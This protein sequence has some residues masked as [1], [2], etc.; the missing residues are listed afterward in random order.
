LGKGAANAAPPPEEPQETKAEATPVA[1]FAAPAFSQSGADVAALA[2]TQASR[3]AKDAE[4]N[5]K[6]EEIQVVEFHHLRSA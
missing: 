5:S 3:K 4:R 2:K 6:R 1:A